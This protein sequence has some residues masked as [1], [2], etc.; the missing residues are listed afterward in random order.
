MVILKFMQ[1]YKQYPRIYMEV[2]V[3]LWVVVGGLWSRCLLLPT[4]TPGHAT[5]CL[6]SYLH[7]HS[8]LRSGFNQGIITV[9]T[10]ILS[11]YAMKSIT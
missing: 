7:I 6:S 10:T 2:I 11:A 1:R 8:Q 4:P 9:E 3:D 5:I